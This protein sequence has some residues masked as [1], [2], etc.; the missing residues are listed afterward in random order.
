MQVFVAKTIDMWLSRSALPR[1]LAV[2]ITWEDTPTVWE[3]KLHMV[4]RSSEQDISKRRTAHSM[5]T[6]AHALCVMTFGLG[7]PCCFVAWINAIQL[8][9]ACFRNLY[10][11]RTAPRLRTSVSSISAAVFTTLAHL[12]AL[13]LAAASAHASS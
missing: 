1:M 8:L 5:R 12:L 9:V 6:D 3:S 7:G 4:T 10:C 2:P 11:R 13:P